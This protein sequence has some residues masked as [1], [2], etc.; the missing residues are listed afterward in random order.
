MSSR[1]SIKRYFVLIILQT[2][3]ANFAHPVTPTLIS[4]LKFH[5]YMFGVAFASMSLTYFLFAPFWGKVSDLIGRVKVLALCCVGYALGQ[6]IMAGMQTELDFILARLISGFFIGGISVCQLTYIID[7]C[8]LEDRGRNLVINATIQSVCGPLGFLMGGLIGT[9]SIPLLFTMQVF[10]LALAG[11]LFFVFLKDVDAKR[12]KV[13]KREFIKNANPFASFI[14][15]HKYLTKPLIIFFVAIVIASFGIT[16]FDQCFNYY[17]KD[18]YGFL[19]AYNGLLKAVIGLIALLANVTICM[20]LMKNTTIK[21]TLVY[22]Y[23]LTSIVAFFVAGTK[24]LLI[25][26]VISIIYFALVAIVTPLQQQVVSLQTTPESNGQI[27]G[28]YSSVNSLGMV[29]GSLF[30]GFIYDF[31]PSIPFLITAICFICIA[32]LIGFTNRFAMKG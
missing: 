15:I 1:V 19:P 4:N 18:V 11:V 9:Y 2:L 20:W 23:A 5:S 25:F 12:K 17:I 10:L 7:V 30:A 16:A 27:M 28:F 24:E 3:A 26:V 22:V 13:T 31:G 21:K 6:W 29:C 32:C 8:S 14:G